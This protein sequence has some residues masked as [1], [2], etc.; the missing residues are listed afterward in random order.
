MKGGKVM[1]VC[2]TVNVVFGLNDVFTLLFGSE[3]QANLLFLCQH[4]ISKHL[5]GKRM[6]E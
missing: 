1:F 6:T 5:Q 3:Q 4:I 2:L